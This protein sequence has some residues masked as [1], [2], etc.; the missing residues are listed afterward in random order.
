MAG[1]RDR[2]STLTSD[3]PVGVA[4]ECVRRLAGNAWDSLRVLLD[5]H[6]RPREEAVLP[7]R[8]PVG[9]PIVSGTD[10][11]VLGVW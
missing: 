9:Q 1:S 11:R 2:R 6:P 4:C 8:G 7:A 3:V 10:H 5:V